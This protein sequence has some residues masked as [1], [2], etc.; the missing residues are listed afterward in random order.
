[1]RNLRNELIALSSCSPEVVV[2]FNLPQPAT[3]HVILSIS[4]KS[5]QVNYNI[6]KGDKFLIKNEYDFYIIIFSPF[7]AQQFK[8]HTSSSFTLLTPHPSPQPYGIQSH[9]AHSSPVRASIPQ[10]ARNFFVV[11]RLYFNFIQLNTGLSCADKKVP[12]RSSRPALRSLINC[13]RFRLSK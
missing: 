7:A 8:F 11:R 12:Q 9:T 10:G 2:N 6:K 3:A 5:P 1:M 13:N 4:E